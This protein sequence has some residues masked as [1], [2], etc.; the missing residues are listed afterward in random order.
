MAAEPHIPYPVD[1]P[2]RG[3]LA[4]GHH[5]RNP[6]GSIRRLAVSRTYAGG[7]VAYV[8]LLSV[9]YERSRSG[10]LVAAAAFA[11][12]ALPALVSPSRPL[13]AIALHADDRFKAHSLSQVSDYLSVL[14]TPSLR[15]AMFRR[16]R[17]TPEEVAAT[18]STRAW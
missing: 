4:R 13:V 9:L 10:L 16:P 12:F 11:A 8:A 3:I 15:N 1:I 18:P 17:E 6:R 7:S 2:H 14:R 5:R